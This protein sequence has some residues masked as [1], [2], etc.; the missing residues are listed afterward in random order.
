MPAPRAVLADITDLRLNPG[1]PY[2]ICD[3]GGRLA[4]TP[5]T[6][7]KQPPGVLYETAPKAEP[8]KPEPVAVAKV[9]AAPKPPPPPPAPVKKEEPPKVEVKAPEPP[10]PVEAPKP[11]EVKAEPV[12]VEA[13]KEDAP[14]PA[15]EAVKPVE[16]PTDDKPAS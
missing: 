3:K 6:G 2:S 11:V 15:A 7:A 16:K 5:K 9:V 12:K 13:K 4:T 8:K 1:N 14:A 10:K